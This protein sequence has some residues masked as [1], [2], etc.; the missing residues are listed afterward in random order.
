MAGPIFM[1]QRF[2]ANLL[3]F[4]CVLAAAPLAIADDSEALHTILLQQSKAWNDGDLD[5]FMA[6]YWKSPELTFSSGG[7]TTRGWQATLERYRMKYPDRVTMGHLAFSN[8]ESRMLGDS[9]ALTLGRW[10]LQRDDAIEGNFSLVWKRFDV[11]WRIVHDHTSLTPS[12]N[13]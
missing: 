9:A 11:G 10:K 13:E 1:V 7:T 8:L 2:V 6:T 5:A 4:A 12:S 3:L